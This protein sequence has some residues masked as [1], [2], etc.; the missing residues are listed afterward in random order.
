MRQTRSINTNEY[1][2]N[3]ELDVTTDYERVYCWTMHNRVI[4]SKNVKFTSSKYKKVLWNKIIDWAMMIQWGWVRGERDNVNE[5]AGDSLTLQCSSLIVT[6]CI[7]RA[8]PLHSNITLTRI[9]SHRNEIAWITRKIYLSRTN[10][11]RLGQ[12]PAHQRFGSQPC[13]L[14]ADHIACIFIT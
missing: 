1:K 11:T 5:R 2:L 13:D 14:G 10:V 7:L 9:E 4:T 12:N 6:P 3:A 8:A